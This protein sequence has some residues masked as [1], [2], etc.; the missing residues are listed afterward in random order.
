V[1]SDTEGTFTA[2]ATGMTTT[3]TGTARYV[4]IGKQVTVLLPGLS[5][6]SN[7]TTFTVTGLPA[8]LIPGT[9]QLLWVYLADAGT[10]LDGVAVLDTAGLLT[11]YKPNFGAF[12]ASGTKTLYGSIPLTYL[13]P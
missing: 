1:P 7:A 11:L 8:G 9:N 2:T 5:G 4:Q 3:V 10:S 12:T 13:L 6:T